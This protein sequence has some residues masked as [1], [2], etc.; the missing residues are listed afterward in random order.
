MMRVN[1]GL[2]DFFL[3]D[4]GRASCMRLL[5]FMVSLAI[6]FA[7]LWGNL[8]SGQY[9]PLVYAEAVLLAAAR[10][11]QAVQGYYEYVPGRG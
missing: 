3:D 11:G 7:W 4:E 5:C 6:L 1:K 10:G 9:V 8:R 2:R